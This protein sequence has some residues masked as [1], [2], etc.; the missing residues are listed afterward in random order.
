MSTCS[1][2]IIYQTVFLLFWCFAS[3]SHWPNPT[4]IQSSR[5]YVEALNIASWGRKETR[6]GFR[7]VEVNLENQKKYIQHIFS[8]TLSAHPP[9]PF[10]L[11]K[12]HY[13]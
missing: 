10:Q 12:L 2:R 4:E 9:C 7:K 8:D 5:D 3:A 1:F 13:G 6:E 11:P